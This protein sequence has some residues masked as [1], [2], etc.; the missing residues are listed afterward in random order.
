MIDYK[1][2]IVSILMGLSEKLKDE[3]RSAVDYVIGYLIGI[4]W[5]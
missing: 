5:Y 4:G 2:Y 3:E 1:K